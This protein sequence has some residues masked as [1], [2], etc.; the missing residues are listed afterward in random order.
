MHIGRVFTRAI[1]FLL[2]HVRYRLDGGI[3]TT[4]SNL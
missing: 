1:T 2:T 3:I 4:S